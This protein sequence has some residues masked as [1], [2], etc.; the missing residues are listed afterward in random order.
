MYAQA[1]ILHPQR[2]KRLFQLVAIFT[3]AFFA[4]QPVLA[5]IACEQA[6][7]ENNR[8]APA[9]CAGMSGMHHEAGAQAAAGC[10]ESMAV[11]PAM[12]GCNQPV[13][14]VAL[15]DN[16]SNAIVSHAPAGIDAAPVA[17]LSLPSLPELAMHCG[18]SSSNV[19]AEPPDRG[20]LFHVFRI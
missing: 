11:L 6:S 5:Y 4:L 12:L 2:M 14:S 20:V 10:H 19:V 17:L 18:P 13:P 8:C 15:V 9:C 7:C 16:E 1:A 3:I